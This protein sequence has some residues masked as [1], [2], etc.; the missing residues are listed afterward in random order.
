M[1]FEY[2]SPQTEFESMI[3]GHFH[4]SAYGKITRGDDQKFLEFLDKTHPPPGTVVYIDSGGGEVEPA[5]EIGR[6]IRS[7]RLSTDVGRYLLG[8]TGVDGLIVGRK[9]EP[10]QC[11]SAAT[12]IYLGGRLRY[13]SNDARFGVHQFSFSDPVPKK[14]Y[15]SQI[16]SAKMARY[17]SDMSISTEF[18][19]ISSR[20]PSSEIL[21]IPKERLEELGVVT[22]GLTNVEWSTQSRGGLIYVRGER[23]SLFGRHKVM[24]KYSKATGFMFW[25]LFEAQGRHKELTEL[26]L[27]EITHGEDEETIDVSAKSVRLSAGEDVNIFVP[28][29]EDEAIFLANSTAFGVQ[30]RASPDAPLFL[31]ASPLDTSSGTEQLTSF[32]NAITGRGGSK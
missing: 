1:R 6:A 32:V 23:D 10:G 22:G 8:G 19:E 15:L 4:I 2:T 3:G 12:L 21:S 18:L 26:P 24:L 16:L 20:T 30:V 14:E 7:N 28:L 27:V 11:M 13:F 31:G 29:S 17:I 25:G 9:K 5:I